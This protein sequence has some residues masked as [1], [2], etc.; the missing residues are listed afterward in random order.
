MTVLG[1][2]E[3]SEKAQ[4]SL[5]SLAFLMSIL[6]CAA[7]SGYYAYSYAVAANSGERI[8]PETTINPNIDTA[9]SMARLPSF[10]ATKAK[11]VVEYRQM[12]NV[13]KNADD[14]DNVKGIGPK[15]VENIRP[16]L[17]FE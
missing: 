8:V 3:Q 12:G 17:R 15:T 5:Q 2:A 1:L 4:A 13:F 6:V 14:L 10:G 7:L 16:Y 11:A 9:V